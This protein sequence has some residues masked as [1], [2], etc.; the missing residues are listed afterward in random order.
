MGA[1]ALEHMN[2]GGVELF[3]FGSLP[4]GQAWERP[5]ANHSYYTSDL[6]LDYR[7]QLD[8]AF[9]HVSKGEVFYCVQ[10]DL[11]GAKSLQTPCQLL[12]TN[13]NEL[14]K[15]VQARH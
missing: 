9:W 3:D 11:Q 2:L 6:C 12:A 8:N 10:G 7:K 15:G 14:L 13:D 1:C 4:I 5:C